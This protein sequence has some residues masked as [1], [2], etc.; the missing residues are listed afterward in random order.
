MNFCAKKDI[1]EYF[2]LKYF[3]FRAKN[4]QSNLY[5]KSSNLSVCP[6]RY[7][8]NPLT[9]D[10]LI[11][12]ALSTHHLEDF[13]GKKIRKIGKKKIKMFFSEIFFKI[14]FLEKKIKLL[15]KNKN[16]FNLKVKQKSLL[17]FFFFFFQFQ[18]LYQN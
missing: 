7:L 10:R 3:N 5:N 11:L 15:K 2:I 1:F 13:Y 14:I 9:Y 18:F 16:L 8:R 6:H 17:F 12:H 4:L